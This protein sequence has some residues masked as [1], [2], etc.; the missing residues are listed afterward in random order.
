MAGRICR[1]GQEMA[2]YKAMDTNRRTGLLAALCPPLHKSLVVMASSM[3]PFQV[4]SLDPL[5]NAPQLKIKFGKPLLVVRITER[6]LI[7][8]TR[9]EII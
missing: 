1:Q 3:E 9:V 6:G 7:L 5:L 4:Q 8:A 2:L